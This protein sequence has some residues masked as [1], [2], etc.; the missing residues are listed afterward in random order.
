[1]TC[2]F[3]NP[4]AMLVLLLIAAMGCDAV[5]KV[6]ESETES[7]AVA[8]PG[9]S[10][11]PGMPEVEFRPPD[12]AAPTTLS[13]DQRLA[14]IL[15][16]QLNILSDADIQTLA[17]LTD[18]NHTVVELDLRGTQL[19]ADSVARLSQLPHLKSL[20]LAGAG[21]QPD[22][23]QALGAMQQLEALDLENSSVSDQTGA[24]L[25][26]LTNLK[27]LNLSQTQVTDQVFHHLINLHNLEEISI[28]KT[29]T[30]GAGFE[31]LGARGARAPLRVVNVMGTAFGQFGPLHLKGSETLEELGAGG[32]GLN[33]EG[34]ALFRSCDQLKKLV[35]GGNNITDQG[36]KFLSGMKSLEYL[37]VSSM[38]FVSNFTLERVKNLKSLKDINVSGTSCDV[39][40][41]QALKEFL[42]DCRILIN[43]STL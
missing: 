42:P 36:L 38:T 43:G 18:V 35:I 25:L 2:S 34:I 8:E 30:T 23:W 32:C 19:S 5:Q 39:Q 22:A 10:D 12:S 40:G 26:Q 24:F 4:T 14:E 11:P 37:D 28:S 9:G 3:Q 7:E 21:W 33:D 29:Q 15:G 1:M 17:T 6:S 16:R 20:N 41:V 31:A 27:K 13:Q